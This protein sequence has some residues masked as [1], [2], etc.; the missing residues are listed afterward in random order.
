[1]QPKKNPSFK[2]PTTKLLLYKESTPMQP[3]H[4]PACNPP[5]QNQQ[6][7]RDLWCLG[8]YCEFISGAGGGAISLGLTFPLYTIITKLQVR[9]NYRGPIDALLHTLREEGWTSLYAGMTPA[10][11]GN[12]YA[13]GNPPPNLRDNKPLGVGQYIFKWLIVFCAGMGM[14]QGFTTIGIHL[15]VRL[16]SGISRDKWAPL[17]LFLLA[18]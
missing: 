11:L 3:M 10:L 18:V 5:P 12:T 13:Q 8:T 14:G 17:W 9:S 16:L 6:W 2:W 1:M 7:W 4:L 15:C